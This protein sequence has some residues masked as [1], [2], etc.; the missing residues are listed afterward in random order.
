MTETSVPEPTVD[1]DES[2]ILST[3]EPRTEHVYLANGYMGTSLDFAGGMLFES[4]PA[5]CYVRGVYTAGGPDII[6]RLAVLPAWNGF[7]YGHPSKLE[8]YCR[9]LDLRHG[10]LRTE[11]TLREERGEVCLAGEILMSRADRHQAAVH[12]TIVPSFDGEVQLLGG[13]DAPIGGDGAVET[14]SADERTLTMHIRVAPYGLEVFQSLRFEHTGATV[15]TFARPNSATA[16]L[17]FNARAGERFAATQLSRVATTLESPNPLDLIGRNHGSYQQIR[18]GH[19]EAWDGLWKTDIEV[20]GD[21]EVQ[22]FARA[23]LFY[24][25]STV[26]EDDE[27]SIAPMGLS[28]NFYNG[29]IFWDA[30][31]WMYPSLLVTQPALGKSCTSYRE[32]TLGPARERAAQSGHSG[33][34]FPWEGG[35]TG[36]EMTP[37]GVETRD[38]QLHITADVAIGQWWYYLATGDREWLRQHGFPLI[39]ECAE[40]WISRVEHNVEANRYEVSNVVCADEYAEHVDNDAF[41]NASVRKALQ[42]A[43]RAAE[44]LG[45][46]APR[47]WSDIADQMY[48]PYDAVHAR[49]LEFDG[50]DGRRTK[51]ADVELLAYPL[52]YTTDRGQ[53]ERD[54][55]YHGTVIDPHGPAMSFSVY[56]IVS[57]QLGR[58]QDA[59]EFLKKS[60][61]PNTKRPFWSFSET[62]TNNEFFF[63][64]GIGGALQTFLFGFSGLRLREDHIVLGPILPPHW[65]ALRLRGL[66]VQGARTDIEIE[67]R[68]TVVRRHLSEGVASA[69]F[70]LDAGAVAFNWSGGPDSLQVEM[71]N[72]EGRLT[73]VV[74]A[75]RGERIPLSP[76]AAQEVRMRL[77]SE[78]GTGLLD[79][80]F[81]LHGA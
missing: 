60:F 66:F 6:D 31:F 23:A 62:P 4:G 76:D 26:R 33:A 47:E 42:I 71:M 52:E 64:T 1:L 27:W 16:I 48:I 34:Q 63:C 19:V 68:R 5:P 50:Y 61:I 41:T 79:V 9:R 3:H 54:L 75:G 45:A 65:R 77:C 81:R 78:A 13:L 18:A 53:I 40:Y 11:M 21:P 38:Y 59:Y 35:Y 20:N 2:W 39:R 56:S 10:I 36:E 43:V 22:Q 28:G 14:I 37:H 7:R 8:R 51:Q 30:E 80:A 17:T 57:A 73:V 25:W 44:I 67:P 49:H 70:D 15:E 24:L 32:R 72:H 69:D 74:N 12:L 55:D 58:A 29:H 46:P